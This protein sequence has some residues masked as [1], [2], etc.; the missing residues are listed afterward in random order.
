V[1]AGSS[2]Q[3]RV[4]AD[5]REQD[6]DADDGAE[7]AAEIKDVAVADAEP[8]GEDQIDEQ[9]AGQAKDEREQPRRRSVRLASHVGDE[10]PSD[11]PGHKTGQRR[12]DHGLF[13]LCGVRAQPTRR[14][15]VVTRDDATAS[16]TFRKLPGR[17]SVAC[18]GMAHG[19]GG[20][21]R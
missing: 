11:D 19:R 1:P 21:E 20:S 2:S 16:R 17:P 14:P 7:D 5:D 12:A 4:D 18:G 3:A 15:S 13:S 9:G 6:D 10:H 8:D